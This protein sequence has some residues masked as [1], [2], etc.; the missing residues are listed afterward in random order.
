M[1]GKTN[2]T[3]SSGG[4][5]GGGGNLVY[6]ENNLIQPSAAGDKVILRKFVAAPD[7]KSVFNNASLSYFNAYPIIKN[8]LLFNNYLATSS[9]A[10]ENYLAQINDDLTLSK[11]TNVTY[12]FNYLS[13]DKRSKNVQMGYY[14]DWIFYKND[15]AGCYAFNLRTFQNVDL[16]SVYI[17]S[18]FEN[19]FYRNEA[20]YGRD[21]NIYKFNTQTGALETYCTLFADIGSDY[22]YMPMGFYKN[23]HLCC[24][25]ANRFNYAYLRLYKINPDT[26]EVTELQNYDEVWNFNYVDKNMATLPLCPG[27][28]FMKTTTGTVAYVLKIDDANEVAYWNIL[29]C[30]GFDSDLLYKNYNVSNQTF[31]VIK[32]DEN[33]RQILHIMKFNP[34][35]WVTLE[36]VNAID[37]TDVLEEISTSLGLQNPS[38]YYYTAASDNM[39]RIKV[40]M[41]GDG[42]Y[43]TVLINFDNNLTSWRVVDNTNYNYDE[44]ALTAFLTG[45]TDEDGK[46]EVKTTLPDKITVALSTGDVNATISVEGND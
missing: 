30:L 27:Y 19:Y 39:N 37:L 46:L 36:M 29:N 18:G 3:I 28:Y 25:D 14:G 31:T 42:I 5:G 16:G 2:A 8:N 4:S 34:E 9:S 20:N 13:N 12:C 15:D 32:P 33:G 6:A 40:V 23:Y 11:I 17:Y 22:N 7:A 35:N 43:H 10:S 1:L 45:N 41:H 21:Q 24:Y 44:L 38:L 26:K